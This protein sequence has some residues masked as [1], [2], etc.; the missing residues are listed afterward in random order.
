MKS[1]LLAVALSA[2]AALPALAAD[3]PIFAAQCSRGVNQGGYNIDTDDRGHLW[4]NGHRVALQKILKH[5][6]EGGYH[7]V[8]F[9][10]SN[11][12]NVVT[13][14]FSGPGRENGMCNVTAQ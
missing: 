2:T 13:V 3:Y 1:A 9:S 4:V 10:I 5:Y 11:A 14:S 8:V 12:G 6:W 7:G